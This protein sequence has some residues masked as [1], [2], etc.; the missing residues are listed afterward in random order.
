MREDIGEGCH[1]VAPR[2]GVAPFMRRFAADESGI[3]IILFAIS[4]AA[5][6]LAAAIAIDFARISLERTEMQRALD[7]A[8]LAAAHRLG[9]PDQEQSGPAGPWRQR[10]AGPG[11]RSH[12]ADEPLGLRREPGA[13][14]SGRRR[15][16]SRDTAA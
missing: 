7:S 3:F 10:G 11:H 16:A 13:A 1:D 5:M 2:E 4:F 15:I 6:A 9:M 12:P 14:S 8:A